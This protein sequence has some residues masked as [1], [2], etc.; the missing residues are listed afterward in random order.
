MWLSIIQHVYEHD[1]HLLNQHIKEQEALMWNRSFVIRENVLFGGEHVE[2]D[3]QERYHL[4]SKAQTYVDEAK[5]YMVF[6]FNL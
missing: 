3:K 4:V 1:D 5:M 6:Y 2:K